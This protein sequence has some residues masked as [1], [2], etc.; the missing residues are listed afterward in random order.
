MAEPYKPRFPEL[1][2]LWRSHDLA[3]TEDLRSIRPPFY[4]GLRR[5]DEPLAWR[6]IEE[7]YLAKYKAFV[8]VRFDWRSSGLW[9][10]PFP[11]SVRYG[12]GLGVN[13]LGLPEAA[14]AKIKD[15]H[16]ELDD[17]DRLFEEDWMDHES[18]DA[19]GL[20][21]AKAVKLALGP[22]FYVEFRP[23][24]EIALVD[25][26]PKELEVPKFIR[27]LNGQSFT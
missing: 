14:L 1:Y 13:I 25:G 4:E 7:D 12:M 26:E 16:D 22:D 9:H 20:E 11:G 3:F 19:K 18:S 8:G 15:W 17:L 23:F 27:D 24:Q 5:E 6:F 2:D 10:I 21:A